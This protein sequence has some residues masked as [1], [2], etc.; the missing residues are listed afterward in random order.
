MTRGPDPTSWEEIRQWRKAQR[1][2][3]IAERMAM[4]VDLRLAQGAAAKQH[5][6]GAVDIRAHRTLGIYWPLR[7]EMDVRD[8]ARA[9]V[10]AGGIVGLPVVVERNAAV[11]FWRWEPG[12]KMDKGIWDIPIPAQRD[13]IHPDM[14]IVPLV[15]FDATCYRLGYGGGYYDRTI[16]AAQPRPLCAGLGFSA[17]ALPSIFPQQHDIPMHMIVTEN[18]VQRR[19]A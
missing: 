1:Q 17:A 12:M 10:E 19:A 16:A 15:G 9:H 5:L 3:L 18:G 13:V 8:I 4:P 6:Q 11:E 14:L 7:G 2:S